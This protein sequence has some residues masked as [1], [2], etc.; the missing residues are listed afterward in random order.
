MPKI[1]QWERQIGRRLRLSDLFVFFTVVKSGSMTKAAAQLNVA[2]PSISEIIVDLE[3][4][5]G[6]RLLDRS[7]R[8]VQATSYGETL[9]KYGEAAFD[10]LRQ[11]IK[12]IEFLADPTTGE[13]R[14]GCPE[15]IVAT[16]LPQIV[17]E[18]SKKHPR[19][20]IHVDNVPTPALRNPGLRDRKYDLILAR[21]GRQP[22]EDLQTDELNVE[23]LLDDPFVL[24]SG[25]QNGWARR[26]KIKLAELTDVPWILTPSN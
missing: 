25:V 6:V 8:G 18:F 5:L 3:Q 12:A 13:L 19:V 24:A 11:G 23:F 22:L 15:S 26:R 10:E 20:I 4:S 14:I 17:Q 7:P 9:M 2:T 16:I 21:L 1:V